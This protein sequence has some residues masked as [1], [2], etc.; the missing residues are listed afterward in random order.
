MILEASPEFSF[1]AKAAA[2]AANPGSSNGS[3]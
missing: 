2:D 3:D 1:D